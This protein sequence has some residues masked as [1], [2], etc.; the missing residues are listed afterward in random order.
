MQIVLQTPS[1]LVVHDGR[2]STA[3]IGMLFTSVGGGFMWLRWTHPAGWSG[4][5]GPWVVYVVGTVFCLVGV[6]SFW[7]SAD[8][9]FI[10]DRSTHTVSIVVR[11]LVHQTT[12]LLAFN[13]IKD[14]ALEASSGM[15]NNPDAANSQTFRGVFLM[16]DG[17]RIPWTPYST[18]ARASQ[19]SCVAAVRAFGGWSENPEHYDAPTTPTPALISHPVATNWGA[20]AAFLSIF[21]AIGLGLFSLEVYRVISW[22]PVSANVIS[23]TVGTVR[24]DKGN[25]YKPVVVYNYGYKGI[26]YEA[27]AATPIS[28]SAGQNW[29]QGIAD[30]F[31]PG[32]TTTAYV[33]P[34]H[35]NN[36]FLLRKV[37]Y[38]PL[39]FV[40]FPLIFGM[41]F[42]W[43][44]RTQ[45]AQ[46]ELAQKHLVPVVGSVSRISEVS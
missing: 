22:V 45:R 38:M 46:V 6:F 44:V 29:A 34:A 41:L 31:Q 20:L 12:T 35:P 30:R 37:S 19:E 15:G 7:L 27:S 25:T 32:Q 14:V 5:G 4:N 1:Q 43:I 21:V 9:R 13:D 24:G 16:K 11:R 10:V 8:R 3:L 42:A 40:L 26:Q 17:S 33:N 36:A 39:I 2:W 28:I 18:S 23:S